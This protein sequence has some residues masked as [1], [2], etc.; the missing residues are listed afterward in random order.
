MQVVEIVQLLRTTASLRNCSLVLAHSPFDVAT[1]VPLM[2][3]ASAAAR[4]AGVA[5]ATR[6]ATAATV[7]PARTA[8]AP[9]YDSSMSSI[10]HVRGTLLVVAFSIGENNIGGPTGFV[11]S[12]GRVYCVTKST[13]DIFS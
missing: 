2:P 8:L 6:P 7:R 9:I 13:C 11:D 4:G 3:Q 12:P 5:E 10:S 1:N